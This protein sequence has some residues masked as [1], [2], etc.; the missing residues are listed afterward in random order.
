MNTVTAEAP[1]VHVTGNNSIGYEVLGSVDA[2]TAR[3]F[4]QATALLGVGRGHIPHMS[5]HPGT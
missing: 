4:D 3:I 5:Y 1:N 2:D